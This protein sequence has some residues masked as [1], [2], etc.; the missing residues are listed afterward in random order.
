ME[1]KSLIKAL[2]KVQFDL[3]RIDPN[4]HCLRGFEAYFSVQCNKEYKLKRQVVW[5]SVFQEQVRQRYLQMQDSTMMQ[6]VSSHASQWARDTA[7][8]LGMADAQEALTIFVQY[9]HEQQAEEED[10]DDEPMME[11]NEN[12]E[13]MQQQPEEE[14]EENDFEPLQINYE[15]QEG[16]MDSPL[17]LPNDMKDAYVYL[18]PT[19][20]T[21]AGHRSS[22]GKG[23]FHLPDTLQICPPFSSPS[24]QPNLDANMIQQLELALR[25]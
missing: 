18:S 23:F 22:N 19:P 4:K 6:L 11:D 14:K 17:S 8:E 16:R 13:I 24:H 2:K 10:D 9:M 7:T 12:E 5:Q 21:I 3:Q 25:L 15:Y 20:M 1:R